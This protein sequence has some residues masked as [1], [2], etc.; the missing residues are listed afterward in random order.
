MGRHSSH[1]NAPITNTA[2]TAQAGNAAADALLARVN[3]QKAA[4][5][6]FNDAFEADMRGE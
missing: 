4:D 2:T 1:Q 5:D 6:A 3:N